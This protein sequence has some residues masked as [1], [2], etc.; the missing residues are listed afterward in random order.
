MDTLL[1]KAMEA[2]YRYAGLEPKALLLIVARLAKVEGFR[3]L[4][5]S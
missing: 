3:G 1:R 2:S 4:P 5:Q